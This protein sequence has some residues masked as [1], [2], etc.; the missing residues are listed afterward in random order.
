MK[1]KIFLEPSRD[2][3]YAVH[4]PA[5]RGC[6]TQGESIEEALEN[7]K[8]AIETYLHTAEDLADKKEHV[9]EVEVAV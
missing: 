2:G 1:F 4:V 3:G 9:Y 8:D 7:A 6:H 5:L